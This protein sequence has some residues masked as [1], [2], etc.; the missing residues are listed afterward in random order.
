MIRSVMAKLL[1]PPALR[2]YTGVTSVDGQLGASGIVGRIRG[3]VYDG[4]FEIRRIT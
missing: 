4:A 3:K 1:S 2:L